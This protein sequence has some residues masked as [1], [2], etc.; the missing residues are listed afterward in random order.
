MLFLSLWCPKLY[1]PH[2]RPFCAHPLTFG[3][4]PACGSF[5]LP[6]RPRRRNPSY[7]TDRGRS[8]PACTPLPLATKNLTPPSAP[9][10][11]S[12]QVEEHQQPQQRGQPEA[13]PH[14]PPPPPLVGVVP[15]SQFSRGSE[16]SKTRGKEE[17]KGSS[18]NRG[19]K[20]SL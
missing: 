16:L 8:L 15:T 14:L 4:A 10:S 19:G 5:A 18:N 9:S 1:S 3:C 20:K 13:P 11:S 17:E 2:S 7:R 6:P 12:T